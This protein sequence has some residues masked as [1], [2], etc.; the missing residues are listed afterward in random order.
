MGARPGVGGRGDAA[1]DRRVGV[2]R[3]RI[4]EAIVEL[5]A[6]TGAAARSPRGYA[7]SCPGPGRAGREPRPR[8]DT[9]A[10]SSSE[11]G[12]GRGGGEWAQPAGESGGVRDLGWPEK[13]TGMDRDES[14]SPQNPHVDLIN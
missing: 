7:R 4:D 12:G 3:R 14:R 1:T 8:L 6:G 5:R 11:W 2:A 10:A 9:L 13:R